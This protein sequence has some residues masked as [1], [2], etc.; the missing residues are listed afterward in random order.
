MR[1]SCEKKTDKTD[2]AGERFS[3][4]PRKLA[5]ICENGIYCL[6]KLVK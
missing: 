4:N 6:L 1:V 2:K 3:N 5:K